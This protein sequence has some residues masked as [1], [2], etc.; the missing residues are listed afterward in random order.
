MQSAAA[1]G[2]HMI[3]PNCGS[4]QCQRLEVIYDAGTN[5]NSSSSAGV[6]LIAGR[7]GVAGAKSFGISRSL[8]ATK[9]SPP[10][11]K[12]LFPAVLVFALGIFL[13]A[14]SNYIL[15]GLVFVGGGML[16][17]SYLYD[18]HVFHPKRL[19]E[20]LRMW[21]CNQ[22]GWQFDPQG[23]SNPLPQSPPLRASILALTALAT[24]AVGVAFSRSVTPEAAS[25]TVDRA[26]N[27]AT[28]ATVSNSITPE[29]PAADNA[30]LAASTDTAPAGNG[31]ASE[32][33]T[34]VT[35]AANQAPVAA[36]LRSPNGSPILSRNEMDWRKMVW[37]VINRTPILAQQGQDRAA[38]KSQIQA[39]CVN[40]SVTDGFMTQSVANVAADKMVDRRLGEL[41]FADRPTP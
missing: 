41:R 34:V 37:C 36:P 13:L 8:Q 7:L 24:I 32:A 18:N 14:V 2:A 16:L 33:S 21:M 22:C 39:E 29:A 12:N 9:I 40:D 31:T 6:G 3:C 15:G 1:Y 5:L 27:A 17:F 26:V 4:N 30:S 19:S 23:V 10:T 11:Q 20:W 28:I 25:N 35:N 38:I